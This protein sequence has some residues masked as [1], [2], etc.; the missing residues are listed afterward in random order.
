MR[1]PEAPARNRDTMPAILARYPVSSP[2]VFGCVARG[3]DGEDSDLDLMVEKDGPLDEQFGLDE[4]RRLA[5]AKC[6]EAIGDVRRRCG[7]FAS[8]IGSRA[9]RARTSQRLRHVQPSGA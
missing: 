5:A 1:P 6:L 2:R 3:E 7:E 4:T 8:G 9:P